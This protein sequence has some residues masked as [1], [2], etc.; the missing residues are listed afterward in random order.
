LFP[1]RLTTLYGFRVYHGRWNAGSNGHAHRATGTVIQ[2]AT[3]A[4]TYRPLS[5]RASRV[6]CTPF[7]GAFQLVALHSPHILDLA[8]AARTLHFSSLLSYGECR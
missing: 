3:L 5:I 1:P 4:V 8:S 2:P 6:A 7:L